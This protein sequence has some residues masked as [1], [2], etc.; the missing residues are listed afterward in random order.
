MRFEK[1]EYEFA[2]CISEHP[3]I[4]M[5]GA[6]GERLKREYHL[7]FDQNIAMARLV[8]EESGRRALLE[9][10]R[11]YA[12]IAEKYSLPF[13]ATTPTRRVNAERMKKAGC[14]YKLIEEN[15]RMLQSIRNQATC[16][17]YVGGLMG[18]KGDAYSNEDAL[19]EQEAYE[20]HS[21]QAECFKKAGADFLYAGIMPELHEAAGM[22]R[23]MEAAGLPYII[24]FTVWK[25]GRL[26]D[27]TTI[28]DAITYIDQCTKIHPVCYMTN[29]SHSKNIYEALQQSFNRNETVQNRFL[30][31]QANTSPLPYAMLD[32]SADLKGSAPETF[33]EEMMHL[34]DISRIKIWG[35][36]CGTDQRHMEYVARR[37][38]E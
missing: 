1:K 28:S 21:W 29:C 26:M 38:R 4:L 36:C 25:D 35:G 30:G 20:F 19:T 12:S 6:L 9:L 32:Q 27:G 18:C 33:A 17:M 7:K 24:S 10:W 14:D 37:L 2:K 8:Q 23:A 15:V 16:E 22:A 31:I 34:R 11:Q 5:E 3:A 13:L